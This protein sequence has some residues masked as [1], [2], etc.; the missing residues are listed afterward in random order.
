MNGKLSA[1]YGQEYMRKAKAYNW[2]ANIETGATTLR[3]ADCPEQAQ[4]G[5]G[6]S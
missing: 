5:L 2:L 4:K 3:D 1:V 6:G